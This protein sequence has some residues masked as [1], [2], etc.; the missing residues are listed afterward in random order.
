MGTEFCRD[1]G[2]G[3][4]RWSRGISQTK[5]L[6]TLVRNEVLAYVSGCHIKYVKLS[7]PT[8]EVIRMFHPGVEG[9]GILEGDP[10]QSIYAIAEIARKPKIAIYKFEN[11]QDM[12]VA[13]L[14]GDLAL[15]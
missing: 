14:K 13:E 8:S 12:L 15:L 7:L 2:D 5:F 11:E 9:I 1:I 10:L 6:V 4:H 3:Y